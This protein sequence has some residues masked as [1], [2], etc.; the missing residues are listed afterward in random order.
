[1][2]TQ[3]EIDKAEQ[4]ITEIQKDY[5]YRIAD[6]SIGELLKKFVVKGQEPNFE[7]DS[8]SGLFVPQ[9]QRDFVWEEKM[10]SKFIESIFMGVPIQPLFAFEL[11]EDGNLELLDGV[12]RLSSIKS[13]YDN[14]LI[15][16]ELEE[17]KALNGFAF[18]DLNASRK[19]KF[20]NTQLKLYIINENTDEGIRADIFR[21]VNEGG[22]RLEP[23]H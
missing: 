12:Q 9:Y 14:I 10:Q 15:L 18:G 23:F 21:R 22:K 1:M 19:R 11:D 4:Q 13:F 6:F 7:D 2:K 17:L 20:L 8:I 16:S 3:E 5:N